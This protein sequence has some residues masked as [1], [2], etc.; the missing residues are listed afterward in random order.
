LPNRFIRLGAANS[1][2]TLAS[3]S[4]PVTSPAPALPAPA[5]VA[6][7]GVTDSIR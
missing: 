7:S 4:T 3:I 2:A 1:A 5:A 6:N